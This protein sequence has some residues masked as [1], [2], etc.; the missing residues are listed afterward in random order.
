MGIDDLKEMRHQAHSV[1][2]IANS[3]KSAI[4][5]KIKASVIS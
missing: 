4:I 5:V 1:C 2:L 3:V